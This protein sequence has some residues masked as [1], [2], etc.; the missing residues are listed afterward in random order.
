MTM[1]LPAVPVISPSVPESSFSRQPGPTSTCV[2]PIFAPAF[3]GT[4][5]AGTEM[6]GPNSKTSEL[7][8][9]P[10]SMR[11]GTRLGMKRSSPRRLAAVA[12]NV[13]GDWRP[14]AFSRTISNLLLSLAIEIKHRHAL[15]VRQHLAATRALELGVSSH[16]KVGLTDSVI[17]FQKP[18]PHPAGGGD[19]PRLREP[20]RFI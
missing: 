4:S 14:T 16:R 9:D 8:D 5:S 18:A 1:M 6:P 15:E 10:F 2:G 3:R 13:S 7:A 20:V 12:E 17:L 19:P 11:I